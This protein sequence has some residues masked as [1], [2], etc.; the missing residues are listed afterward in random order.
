MAT[1]KTFSVQDLKAKVNHNNRYSTC[2]R[3]IRQGWNHLLETVLHD[4][5]NYRGF[6]FLMPGQVPEGHPP[7]INLVAGDYPKGL[8]K[9][10]QQEELF[11]GC[12]DTRIY[13]I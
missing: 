11:K 10:D 9:Q 12:D 7:G 13:Y 2:S 5:G 4:T 8:D 3:E 1:R 6:G